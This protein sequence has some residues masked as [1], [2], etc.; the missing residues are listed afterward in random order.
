M[1]PTPAPADAA[2]AGPAAPGL[3]GASLLLV[4]HGSRDPRSP[5]GL[6][7]LT[8]AVAVAAAE[9]DSAG[10]D[11]AIG[12]EGRAGI[13]AGLAVEL[14]F[15][16]LSDPLLEDVLARLTGEV[17][18]VPLLLASAFHARSDLPE[19]LGAV[20][21]SRDDVTFRRADVLGP[22]PELDAAVAHRGRGLLDAGCDALVLLGTGSSHEAANAEVDA[23]AERVAADLGAD[24]RAAFVTR[25]RELAVAVAELRAG[26][27]ARVGLVPWFLAPGLLL[28]SGLATAADLGVD[29]VAD[30]LAGEPS[31]ARLVLARA[32]AAAITPASGP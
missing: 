7:V 2:S 20:A 31:L 3:R 15:L 14:A 4:G 16:E 8:D 27:A 30:T 25:G 12:V 9:V 22:A 26:G 10:A 17:V 19:R 29:D 1:G 5:A 21:D 13:D 32:A 11:A 18:V 28:D 6:R 23:V 24:V